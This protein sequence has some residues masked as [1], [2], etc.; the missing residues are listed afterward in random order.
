MRD[1]EKR[2]HAQQFGLNWHEVWSLED[3]PRLLKS[4]GCTKLMVPPDKRRM[5]ADWK[6]MQESDL[7]NKPLPLSLSRGGYVVKYFQQSVMLKRE[8]ELWQD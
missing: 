7:R 1:T 3:L 2:K 8:N 5:K 6:W 4:M